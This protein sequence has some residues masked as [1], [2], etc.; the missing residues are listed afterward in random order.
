MI[1]AD[2]HRGAGKG[3]EYETDC[4]TVQCVRSKG[5]RNTTTHVLPSQPHASVDDAG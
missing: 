1:K 5:R 4:S 3:I 2:E